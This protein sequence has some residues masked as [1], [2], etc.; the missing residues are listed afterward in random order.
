MGLD[1][2]RSEVGRV[3]GQPL[4]MSTRGNRRQPEQIVD[5]G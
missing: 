3:N 4:K 1:D 5:A 2:T